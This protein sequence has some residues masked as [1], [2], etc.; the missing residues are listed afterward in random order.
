VGQVTATAIRATSQSQI[1]RHPPR[2]TPETAFPLTM[3]LGPCNGCGRN[4]SKRTVCW[5]RSPLSNATT[6]RKQMPWTTTSMI[7][8]GPTVDIAV[9]GFK[10]RR[11]VLKRDV[12]VYEEGALDDD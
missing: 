12:P 1:L 9:S 10:I 11:G 3:S 5:R 6:G 2:C 7:E 8:S 4:I